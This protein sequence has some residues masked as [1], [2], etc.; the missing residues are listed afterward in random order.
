[1][2]C[3]SHL[4]ATEGRKEAVV[5]GIMKARAGTAVGQKGEGRWDE[6]GE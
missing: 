5:K 2:L 3:V 1:M 6:R 4:G